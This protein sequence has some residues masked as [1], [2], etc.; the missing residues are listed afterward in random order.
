VTT[1]SQAEINPE[2]NAVLMQLNLSISRQDDCRLGYTVT[3]GHA[4]TRYV[5]QRVY[6]TVFGIDERAGSVLT[7]QSYHHGRRGA[8]AW[9]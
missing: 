9:L 8:C 1:E 4:A 5:G 7:A 6:T 3:H 2:A